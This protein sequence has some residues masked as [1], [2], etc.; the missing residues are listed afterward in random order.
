M[1]SREVIRQR[2]HQFFGRWEIELPLEAL[3]PGEVWFIVQRGWTIWTR[4]TVG[5]EEGQT[6]LDDNAM[7]RMTNDR[8]VR[9]H[10]NGEEECLPAIA[11][12]YSYPQDA[13]PEEKARDEYLEYDRGIEK[14]LQK[15][16]FLMTNQAHGCAILNRYLQ[17]HPGTEDSA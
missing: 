10:A 3:V 11:S 4:F 14:L 13:T 16:G 8:H 7:H 9:V 5:T 1:D 6:F 15:K 12:G 2:I 17:T